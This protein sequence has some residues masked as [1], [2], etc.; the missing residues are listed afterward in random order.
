[1]SDANLATGTGAAHDAGV[2]AVD[3]IGALQA[4]LA[5]AMAKADE[6]YPQRRIAGLESRVAKL[7]GNLALAEAELAAAKKGD[8]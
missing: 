4:A 8:L 6:E 5:T 2:V 7:K 3:N 1:M